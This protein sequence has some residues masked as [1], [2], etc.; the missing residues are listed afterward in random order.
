[1]G[2]VVKFNSYER[3][4][5]LVQIRKSTDLPLILENALLQFCP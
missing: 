4:I 2:V 1:M 5:L 3:F